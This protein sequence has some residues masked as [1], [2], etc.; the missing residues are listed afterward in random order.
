MAKFIH[1]VAKELA[2]ERR[3]RNLSVEDVSEKSGYST[4]YI[5]KKEC[6]GRPPSFGAINAWA[7]TLGFDVVLK[8]KSEPE[9]S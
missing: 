1:P 3:E 4:S 6:G 7:E 5:R 8:K 9:S 2:R